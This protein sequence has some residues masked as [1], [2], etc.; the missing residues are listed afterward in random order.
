MRAN[1]NRGARTHERD[2]GQRESHRD[3]HCEEQMS[4]QTRIAARGLT[5]EMMGN[6]N[7]IATGIASERMSELMAS[8]VA[9][10]A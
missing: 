3:R 5:S 6:A 1:A 9:R 2:D 7:R 10:T 8:R 4:G